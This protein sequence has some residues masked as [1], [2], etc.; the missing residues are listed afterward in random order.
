MK[1]IQKI[2]SFGFIIAV[3]ILGVISMLGVWKIFSNDVIVKSF[4]TLGLLAIISIIIIFAGK[5][6]DNKNQQGGEIID[7]DTSKP[8]FQ[9]IRHLTLTVLII[10]ISILTLFGILA[11]WDVI[12]D[13]D[14]LYKVIGSVSILAFC[15]LIIVMTCLNQEGKEVFKNGKVSGVT[16]FVVLFFVWMFISFLVRSF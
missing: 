15:S 13:K 2:A 10:S 16:V 11:I 12:S 1:K 9:T 14:L 6:I 7:I 8:V 5:F 3:S 4:E